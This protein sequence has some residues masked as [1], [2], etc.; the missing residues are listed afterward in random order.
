MSNS[1]WLVEALSACR[2]AGGRLILGDI[3]VGLNG[4]QVKIQRDL[5][6]ALDEKRPGDV[7]Q[8]E[9][10]RDGAKVTLDLTL[11]GRDI[12]GPND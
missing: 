6:E 8:V 2:D 3:I 1:C 11:G 4:K 7:V 9:L 12:A 5:F 10:L